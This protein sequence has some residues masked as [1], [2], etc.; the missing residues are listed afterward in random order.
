V[1]DVSQRAET[2]D[3]DIHLRMRSSRSR[4]E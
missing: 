2:D 3:E 1:H 4:V